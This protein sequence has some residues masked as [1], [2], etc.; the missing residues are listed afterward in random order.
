MWQGNSYYS[1]YRRKLTLRESSWFDSMPAG[2]FVISYEKFIYS[3]VSEVIFISPVWAKVLVESVWVIAT[4]LFCSKMV[5]ALLFRPPLPLELM[6]SLIFTA[7][8]FLIVLLFVGPAP[9]RPI[10]RMPWILV[11]RWSQA[12]VPVCN[13]ILVEFITTCW[14][15]PSLRQPPMLTLGNGL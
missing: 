4:K 1:A 5:S 3:I 7:L 2:F 8:V 14:G 13:C 6:M 11:C 9:G 12:P 15:W 10:G